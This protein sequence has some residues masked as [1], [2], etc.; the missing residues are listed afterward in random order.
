VSEPFAVG[1]SHPGDLPSSV[2]TGHALVDSV[3]ASLDGLEQR[4]LAE[5]VAVFEV[6]HDGLRAALAEADGAPQPRP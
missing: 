1:T 6:A 3:L 2:T 4:P 5:H